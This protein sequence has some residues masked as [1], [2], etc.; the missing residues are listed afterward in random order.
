MCRIFQIDVDELDF[1]YDYNLEEAHNLHARFD[2][3]RA[4]NNGALTTDDLRRVALWKI[5]RILDVP[6]GLLQQLQDIARQENLGILPGVGGEQIRVFFEQFRELFEQLVSRKGIGFPMASAILKFLRPDIFPIIDVRAY[7]A[8]FGQRL[9]SHQYTFE[10]YME[11]VESVYEIR[12]TYDI[13]LAGVDEQLYEFDRE[14][15]G[16]IGA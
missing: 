9:R 6:D 8:L 12:D 5:N 2:Q 11:Y 14:H 15:N 7:R 1:P 4:N 10:I 16:R 3:I 13:E